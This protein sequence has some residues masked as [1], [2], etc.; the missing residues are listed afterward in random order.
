MENNNVK[1]SFSALNPYIEKN[2]IENIEKETSSSSYVLWG[3]NN[4]YPSYL[5]DLFDN[6]PTLQTIINTSIDY[7][8]GDEI[9]S[10]NPY[11]DD[12]D[13]E[14]IFREITKS[15]YIFGG[16]ALNVLRN[17]KGEIC[18]ICPMDFKKLRTSKDGNV[19]FY[20]RDYNKKAYSRYS[21]EKYPA[22]KKDENQASS[23][24]YYKNSKYTNYPKPIWSPATTA[25]E[26]ERSI[27][28]Y[29][30]NSINNNFTGSVMVCLNNGVPTDEVK[31][32]IEKMFNEKFSGKENAGRIVISYSND[33]EHQASIQKIDTEDFSE[34]YKSL[35]ERS[36]EAIFTSFRCTP[37]LCGIESNQN[38]FSETQY[39]EQY[40]L[41]NRT[42][43]RP[44]QKLL[45]RALKSIFGEDYF[46]I[47]PFSLDMLD[48][49]KE[50]E[51]TNE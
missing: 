19:I 21:W 25:C 1:L 17:K 29:H 37:T 40:K 42:T 22:F 24:F 30:I 26:L 9:V 15:Y 10:S 5:E 41:F 27:D 50:K 3:V 18:K 31:D 49:N 12:E 34:R 39:A 4:L 36:K 48:D 11:I 28:E 35:A 2:M 38:G 32:E 16:F 51:V 33:V 44:T 13:A 46:T 14:E 23:I 20:A 6:C 47:K 7:V 8:L 43:I 45:K